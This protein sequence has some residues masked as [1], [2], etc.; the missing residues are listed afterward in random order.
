MLDKRKKAEEQRKKREQ[1]KREDEKREVARNRAEA[2]QRAKE[3]KA[4]EKAAAK[5]VEKPEHDNIVPETQP[6]SKSSG[7]S[8]NVILLVTEDSTVFASP[9]SSDEISTICEGSFLVAAGP[10]VEVDGY[11]MVPL[12][13]M[14]SVELRTVKR[15]QA[16]SVVE[17]EEAHADAA[18]EVDRAPEEAV[19]KVAPVKTKTSKS[20]KHAVEEDLDDLLNEFGLVPQAVEKSS[21]KK[22]KK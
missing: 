17:Q 13:P 1:K 5:V 3:R 18:L 6:I 14:G 16:G 4:Q 2:A 12:Q 15:M 20:G 10:P 9:E 21:K 11:P 22:G 7:I 8:K 19:S